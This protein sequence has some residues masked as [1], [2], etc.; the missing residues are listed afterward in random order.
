MQNGKLKLQEV[1]RREVVLALFLFILPF[2]PLLHLQFPETYL[3]VFRFFG[4][5]F[6]GSEYTLDLFAWDFLRRLVFALY[7]LLFY[8]SSNNQVKSLVSVLFFLNIFGL[9]DYW[10]NLIK[11]LTTN[12][13]V[14]FI[15]LLLSMVIFYLSPFFNDIKLRVGVNKSFFLNKERLSN[16]LIVT[17][18]SFLYLSYNFSI[19][20]GKQT[21]EFSFF[22]MGSFG[23]AS[24][25]TF[26]WVLGFKISSSLVTTFW[27]FKEKRWWRYALLSPILV[28]FHQ[29]RLTLTPN[30]VFLDE[31]EFLKALPLFA[32]VVF[33]L[34]LLSKNAKDQYYFRALYAEAVLS[35]ER[36]A[37]RKYSKRSDRIKEIKE[38]IQYLKS[39]HS[40]R[41]ANE[42]W[43]L[44]EEL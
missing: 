36:L 22:T 16:Y 12:N 26:L 5:T 7:C 15:S 2:F 9:F 18:I 44:K 27:F 1:H 24:I 23:F 19:F 30:E 38:K 11:E 10:L 31:F 20:E 29:I 25:D 17:A 39:H 14:A 37:T 34:V 4:L 13:M 35:K 8:Y 6:N 40:E 33:V 21:L 32:L 3:P 42:L 43:R 41:G 28:S